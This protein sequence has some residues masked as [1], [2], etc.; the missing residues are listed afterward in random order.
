MTPQFPAS[1]LAP[2]ARARALA[3]RHLPPRGARAAGGSLPPARSGSPTPGRF[4]RAYLCGGGRSSPPSPRAGRP[5]LLLLHLEI[6]PD[7][8]GAAGRR[9]V[10]CVGVGGRARRKQ[11]SE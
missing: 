6:A 7:A 4:R 3:P 11:V 9:G 1:S 10:C 8:I 2:P 5:P